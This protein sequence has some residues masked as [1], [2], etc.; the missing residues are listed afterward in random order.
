MEIEMSKKGTATQPAEET[1][2]EDDLEAVL[3]EDLEAIQDEEETGE[4]EETE[5]I[6]DEELE[7]ETGEE[8]N[9]EE[10]EEDPLEAPAHW[11][12]ED[13]ETFNNAPREAQE[14]V[15]RRHKEMEADYTR[16]T[17]ETAEARKRGEQFDDVLA[18]YRQQFGLQ[19]MDDVGAVRQLFS[20]YGSL[21]QNPAETIQ[22]LAQ[23]Y[24]IDLAQPKQEEID[25]VISQLNQRFSNLESQ[26]TQQNQTAAMQAQQQV[27]A[28][29]T[30]FAQAKDE[31]GN[32]K[33]PHFETVKEQMGRLVGSGIASD[34][35]D[36]YAK[37]VRLHPDL[38][39]QIKTQ[40]QEKK[41]REAIER[42]KQ[43]AAKAKKAASGVKS[44]TTTGKKA[45][46]EM[47]LEDEIRSLVN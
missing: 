29:I 15:L 31:A 4:P 17:Q 12:A 41:E 26:I 8:E 13:R 2:I 24:G 47:S 23:Q 14:F 39:E 36:A 44:G 22:W 19:G 43:A 34:L 27:S 46:A 11:S 33:H 6:T 30:G 40:E 38:T 3:E 25:P 18:P 10:L 35:D 5:E 16:K 1:S 45:P 32:L 21:Q 7:E 9:D 37:A 28:Q 20:I 42:K